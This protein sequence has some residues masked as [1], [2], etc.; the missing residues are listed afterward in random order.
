MENDEQSKDLK[1]ED[2]LSGGDTP[3]CSKLIMKPTVLADN[4]EF[5]ENGFFTPV[6]LKSNF[7][8][9]IAKTSSKT[10]PRSRSKSVA[11]K[12]QTSSPRED[13]QKK[14]KVRAKSQ[15]PVPS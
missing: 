7:A 6:T 8:K 9:T 2:F 4:F 15:L 11:I 13:N 12:R 14:T 3:P 10:V 5:S 1:R